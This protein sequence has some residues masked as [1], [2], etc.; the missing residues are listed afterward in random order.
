VN[1]ALVLAPSLRSS[2]LSSLGS[3]MHASAVRVLFQTVSLQ[4]NAKLEESRSAYPVLSN[5]ARYASNVKTLVIADPVLPENSDALRPIDA[6][7]LVRLLAICAN[8]EALVWESPFPPPD[9]L[10][11][12]CPF[13]ETCITRFSGF[14]RRCSP[15]TTRACQGWSLRPHR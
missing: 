11:E 14:P 2:F 4:D 12:V 7:I 8:I 9:G 15:R 5:P 6:D 3:C 1:T 13:C 10:C